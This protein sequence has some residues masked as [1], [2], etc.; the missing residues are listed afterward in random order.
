MLKNCALST[1]PIINKDIVGLNE[2]PLCRPDMAFAV[3]WAL[4]NNY[5]S[6]FVLLH[7]G[8]AFS[9]FPISAHTPD[10]HASSFSNLVA[11]L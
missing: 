2:I 9:R 3:D 1:S 4:N 8:M 5:L 7:L 10:P 11:R 6:P